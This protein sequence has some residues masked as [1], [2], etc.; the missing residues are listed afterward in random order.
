MGIGL[1]FITHHVRLGRDDQGRGQPLELLQRRV[2]GGRGR[3]VTYA[4]VWGVVIPEPLHRL[5][6]EPWTIGELLVG[7]RGKG[8]VGDRIEEELETDRWTTTRLGQQRD[9]HS[10][11]A[12]HAVAHDYQA[13][14][15]DVQCLAMLRDPHGRRVRLLNRHWVVGF[16][17]RGVVDED[18]CGMRTVGE[19]TDEAIMGVRVAKP[20]TATVKVHHDREGRPTVVG[21]DDAQRQLAAIDAGDGAVLDLDRELLHGTGL[22]ACKHAARVGN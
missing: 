19:F 22:Y 15:V 11:G 20:P 7:R 3:L 9:G 13:S 1:P 6:C 16:R 10:Y 21:A 17:R 8:G 14:W 18:H 12:A 5:A 4:R 2:Q